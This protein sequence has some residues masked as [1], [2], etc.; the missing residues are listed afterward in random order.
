MCRLT[1]G[2]RG[3]TG[4]KPRMPQPGQLASLSRRALLT[5]AA[6]SIAGFALAPNRAHA[7][8]ARNAGVAK[9][10]GPRLKPA[11]GGKAKQLVIFLHGWC[12]EGSNLIDLGQ[13]WKD[14]LPDAAFAAPNAPTACPDGGFQWYEG[15]RWRKKGAD[16]DDEWD[17]GVNWRK[18]PMLN[19]F[20]DAELAALGLA[21]SDLALAGFSQGALM[22]LHVGLRRPR[23]IGAIVSFS[24]QLFEP[25]RLTTEIASR[26][27]VLLV[28]G[29]ADD[30]LPVSSLETAKTALTALGVSVE[31]HI[32]P[33]MAHT[34][35]E[36]ATG[37]SG[38]FLAKVF[39]R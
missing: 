2:R 5:A 11:S 31:G 34:I 38:H 13:Q 23:Q 21:D 25:S 36:E 32:C 15:D 18:A 3:W 29:D 9:L 17:E 1:D 35:N 16:G 22:A 8:P 4:A 39:K 28:H 14:L 26:P 12:S 7:D 6:A 19:A 27:P 30:R 10:D 20:I 24:G 33:G 37:F